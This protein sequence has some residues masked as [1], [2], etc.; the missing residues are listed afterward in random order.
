MGG[1]EIQPNVWSLHW[2]PD[3]SKTF[4]DLILL[5]RLSF[6]IP[7]LKLFHSA[8]TNLVKHPEKS[9]RHHLAAV[10]Q[11][12]ICFWRWG[13]QTMP[14]NIW[15]LVPAFLESRHVFMALAYVLFQRLPRM[16][17]QFDPLQRRLTVQAFFLFN[18]WLRFTAVNIGK[19]WKEGWESQFTWHQLT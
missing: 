19:W 10:K 14:K 4:I 18:M 2:L 16:A 8:H 15:K 12:Q 9:M 11:K 5:A 13:Q 3:S 6:D 1:R 7:N 17:L